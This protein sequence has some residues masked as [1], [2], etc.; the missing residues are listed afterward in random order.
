[1]LKVN[2]RIHNRFDV[3]KKSIITGEEKQVAFAENI[4]L[5]QFWNLWF[6]TGTTKSWFDGI[7]LGTGTGAIDPARTTLFNQIHSEVGA[8]LVYSY[9]EENKV[10]SA[11]KRITLTETQYVGQFLSEVGIYGYTTSSSQYLFTHALLQDMN[12]NQVTIEK[13]ATDIITI[14]ATAYVVLDNVSYESGK[15][16]VFTPV[17]QIAMATD[18]GRFVKWILGQEETYYLSDSYYVRFTNQVSPKSASMSLHQTNVIASSLPAITFNSATKTMT[19]TPPRLA[20]GSGNTAGGIY[21]ASYDLGV[22]V[23]F[24]DSAGFSGSYIA[25][26]ILGTGDEATQDFKTAYGLIKAGAVVKRNGVADA[27]ATIDLGKPYDNNIMK[28][29]KVLEY[30]Y[31]GMLLGTASGGVSGGGSIKVG[32]Y[33]IFENPYYATYGIYSAL[34]KYVTL[35]ASDDL[36]TW[37]QCATAAGQAQVVLTEAYRNCRYFK[38]VVNNEAI[39][40]ISN[41]VSA[42]LDEAELKD[43]HFSSPPD[44]EEVLTIDY[45]TQAVAKDINHVFDCSMQVTFN[46]YTEE[47]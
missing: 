29:C 7:R 6:K 37:N 33:V 43:V 3:F 9:D 26:E 15:S 18:P 45:T 31:D 25:G 24:L 4:I 27:T 38:A 1:M 12:G 47:Y 23:I 28:H 13:T 34:L 44:L 8:G 32:E 40:S 42:E 20:V 21:S 36:A 16:F 17:Q 39:I 30:S 5:D 2:A 46:E 10:W 11:R 41:F 14:Y 22:C 19:I 35:Y